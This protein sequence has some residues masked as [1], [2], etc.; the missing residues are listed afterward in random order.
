MSKRYLLGVAL[1]CVA[2]SC[3][4]VD[5]GLALTQSG[6]ITNNT[7]DGIQGNYTGIYSPWFSAEFGNTAKLY[8]SAKISTVYSNKEW[9]PEKVPILAELGRFDFSLRPFPSAFVDVGRVQFQDMT[10]LIASGLFDGMS[11][12]ITVGKLQVNLGAF[13]TGLQY[14][15]SAKIL[16]TTID[17]NQYI[18]PFDYADMD[19]Y[20]ASRRMV[21]SAGVD[22]PDLSPHTTLFFS[23]LAQFDL[24]SISDSDG[25]TLHSQYLSVRFTVSP[26]E[27][28]MFAGT[29]IAEL[30]ERQEA[31]PC[32]GFAAV[33]S[34]NWKVPG[35]LQDLLQGEL[36]WS[37]GAKNETIGAFTPLT[38]TPQGQIFS[39]RLS[40]LLA[41]KGKYTLR[42]FRN[43][44]AAAEGSYFI[45][46]D[47]E[48]I[49][50][51]NYPAS[52]KRLLG[53]ELYGTLMWAPATDL[54]VTVGGGVFLPQRGNSFAAD[55][56]ALWKITAGFILSL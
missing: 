2:L 9:K 49:I 50:G 34:T 46:T 37:S 42:F 5:F 36:R 19:S 21:I 55:A 24:N 17:V 35:A 20:F 4:A 1:L 52:G 38:A 33:L 32:A 14:K 56:P 8:L 16:M 45:R 27:S 15:E 44:S 18:K 51:E 12:S 54:M 40:G 29:G 43:F 23:T 53:G 6:E 28:L 7:G 25:D 41:L 30:M 39:P 13:Y 3:F 48:T 47:G 31:D 10:E 11:G 22:F 26:L